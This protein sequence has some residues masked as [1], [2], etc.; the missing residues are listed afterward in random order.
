VWCSHFWLLGVLVGLDVGL[1]IGWSMG[2]VVGFGVG[3]TPGWSLGVEGCFIFGLCVEF[4][5]INSGWSPGILVG[6][7]VGLTLG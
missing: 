3:P 6:T 7:C 1:E 5:H 2:A 4:H